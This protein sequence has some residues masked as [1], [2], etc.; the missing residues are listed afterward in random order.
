MTRKL[1]PLAAP[2]LSMA[3][4]GCSLFSFGPRA[5]APQA[6]PT[7][8]RVI[9]DPVSG[10]SYHLAMTDLRAARKFPRIKLASTAPDLDPVFP[11]RATRI[12]AP[13]ALA[14]VAPTALESGPAAPAIEQR[15]AVEAPSRLKL[16]HEFASIS[17]MVPF[18]VNRAE[19]GPLGRKAVAELAPI[20]REARQVIVRGRTDAS[21]SLRI[22][23]SLAGT[24]AE[25]VAAALAAAGVPRERIATSRCTDCY[26]A[27]NTTP[28][29]RSLNRRAD[30]EMSLTKQRIASL[31]KP[32]Y[33]LETPP[34]IL[35]RTLSY[36]VSAAAR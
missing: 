12:D 8:T 3:V 19:L 15:I 14:L 10:A 17:R 4:A 1:A 7:A 34:L 9:Y 29:G 11:L 26:I 32:R 20:A 6:E 13:P 33:A 5:L 36:P 22:N 27:A 28:E 21:G 16:D 35:A 30:V 24:R 2:L 31:P 25:T 18:A 23:E